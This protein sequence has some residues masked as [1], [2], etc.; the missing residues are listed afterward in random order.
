V[1]VVEDLLLT[2]L[3]VPGIT[4]RELGHQCGASG[5][6]GSACMSGYDAIDAGGD[7]DVADLQ[8][9]FTATALASAARCVLDTPARTLVGKFLRCSK[10]RHEVFGEEL[11]R[12]RI[13]RSDRALRCGRGD[14]C[15]W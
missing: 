10:T 14:I 6:S 13:V 3:V 1:L 9:P 11:A 7:P 15:R 12:A 5:P 4:G 2:D 8:K